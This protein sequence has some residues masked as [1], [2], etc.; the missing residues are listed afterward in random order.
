MKFLLLLSFLS[1]TLAIFPNWALEQFLTDE[2]LDFFDACTTRDENTLKDWALDYQDFLFRNL[3]PNEYLYRFP[4]EQDDNRILRTPEEAARN[5]LIIKNVL[6]DRDDYPEFIVDLHG[7][8]TNSIWNFVPQIIDIASQKYEESGWDERFAFIYFMPG[9]GKH[10]KQYLHSPLKAEL[11]DLVKRQDLTVENVRNEGVL[12][13]R[14]NGSPAHAGRIPQPS[15]FVAT[16]KRPSNSPSRKG[17][18]HLHRTTSGSEY[19]TENFSTDYSDSE[20][21]ASRNRSGFANRSNPM[22]EKLQRMT[23]QDT[24]DLDTT[25]TADPN[26]E[27]V[28]NGWH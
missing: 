26:G 19:Y 21:Q 4:D 8:S 7:Q 15:E 22:I 9:R 27:L 1:C 11:I 24:Q 18:S 2:E 23:L 28:A 5:I 14:L 6:M 17:K 16:K 3:N 13:V 20:Y 12:A 25:F 10:S